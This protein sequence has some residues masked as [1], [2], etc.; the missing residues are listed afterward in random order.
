MQCPL[1]NEHIEPDELEFGDIQEIEGEYWHA[2]CFSEYF[3]EV[4]EVA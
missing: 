2:E 3:E 4:L 1:C